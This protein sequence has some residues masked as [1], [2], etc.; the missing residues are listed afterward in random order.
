MITLI[1]TKFKKSDNQ[2]NIDKYRVAANVSEYYIKINLPSNHH[3]KIH[4]N[5]A[6]ILCKND[7]N[8]QVYMVIWSFWS[9][10]SSCCALYIV[11]N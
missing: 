8:Q 5:K 7:K 1:E 6:V 10:L 9:Q 3:S 2:T 4:N 11:P